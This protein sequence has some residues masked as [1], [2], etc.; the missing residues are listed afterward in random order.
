ML[1]CKLQPGP[2]AQAAVGVQLLPQEPVAQSR[3]SPGSPA[4]AQVRCSP[5]HDPSLGLSRS[6]LVSSTWLQKK[7]RGFKATIPLERL[8]SQGG[9]TCK[10]GV[11]RGS[12]ICLVS[13]VYQSTR[14]FKPARYERSVLRSS[15][16]SGKPLGRGLKG[17]PNSGHTSAIRNPKKGRQHLS[18][19]LLNTTR[20]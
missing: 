9:N 10:T 3:A 4:D 11:K 18:R 17:H 14:S 1:W 5:Q 12:E 15:A 20:N 6:G 16:K 7:R 8:R 19:P 2:W 13:L